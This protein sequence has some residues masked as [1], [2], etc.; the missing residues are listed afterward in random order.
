MEQKEIRLNAPKRKSLTND[1]RR[2]EETKDSHEKEEFF[3][4]RE[5]AKEAID[6]AFATMKDV[7]ERRFELADVATL[8]TLQKKYN[9]VNAVGTDSC[10][11]MKVLTQ[12]Y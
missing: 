12:R 6:S 11:F 2:H 5:V 1:Y 7:V 4:S 9:T 3:Q 10:F 8:E